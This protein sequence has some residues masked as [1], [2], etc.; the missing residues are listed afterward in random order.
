MQPQMAKDDST[1]VMSGT[2]D[3]LLPN[4][5]FRVM[6][7]N[8]HNIIAYL[9]GRLRQNNIKILMGDSVQVEMSAYDLSRGR[10]TYR[11]K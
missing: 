4:A 8:K 7:E 10:I 9:S 1:I 3:E 11:N 6:L 5:T 2:V